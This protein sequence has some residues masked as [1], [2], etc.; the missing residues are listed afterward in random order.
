MTDLDGKNFPRIPNSYYLYIVRLI[1]YLV[2]VSYIKQLFE[3]SVHG[4]VFVVESSITQ[5]VVYQK[6]GTSTA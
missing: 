3:K 4:I 6:K 5:L 2:F 1:Q